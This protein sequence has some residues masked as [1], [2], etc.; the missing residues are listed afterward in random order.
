VRRV[1][2]GLSLFV[3]CSGLA[4]AQGQRS[5]GKGAPRAMRPPATSPTLFEKVWKQV[6]GWMETYDDPPT[7]DRD[8]NPVPT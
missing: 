7:P 1:L 5:T 6:K 4:L 3:L 2:F 8:H